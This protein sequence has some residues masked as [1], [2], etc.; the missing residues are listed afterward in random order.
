MGRERHFGCGCLR[1]RLPARNLAWMRRFSFLA[2][3][4]AVAC[5]S[6]AE[7][8]RPTETPSPSSTA[9]RSAPAPSARPAVFQGDRAY[10]T[11]VH[12]ASVIGAREDTDPSYR[13]AASFIAQSFQTLGYR[14][15]R[16]RF[17]V[18]GGRSVGFAIP[19]G[20]SE[21]VIAEPPGFDQ[22]KPHAL[23]G[24]HLDTVV[25]TPGA[26]DNASGVGVMM[27]L[28]RLA[29]LEAPPVPVVFV[30]FGAEERRR[31]GTNGALYGSRHYVNAMSASR[32]SALRAV[33]ILDVVG[34]GSVVL[35]CSSGRT[36]KT[37]INA[38]IAAAKRKGLRS[39]ECIS[40]RRFSDNVSFENAGFTVAWYYTGNFSQ[41][42]TRRDNL[43][44]ISRVHLANVGVAAWEGLR[45]LRL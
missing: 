13:E 17:P 45:T 25:G 3:C 31:S 29:R 41:L 37:L 19:S 35:V 11:L 28:A 4:V 30:A 10:R 44:I 27:E 15:T 20:T 36:R 1:A 16:Q 14:V 18:P 21:N 9:S 24:A 34:R 22:T 5:T 7:V 23:V 43:S 8:I 32:R 6:S 38:M 40:T 12:L 26:N 33:I 39:R 2:L 42:H